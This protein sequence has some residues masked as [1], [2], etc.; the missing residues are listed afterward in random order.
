MTLK[1][2]SKIATQKSKPWLVNDNVCHR[3]RTPARSISGP[4]KAMTLQGS[5]ALHL[6]PALAQIW[7]LRWNGQGFAQS[8]GG[9]DFRG[10]ERHQS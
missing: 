4:N 1:R 9:S 7:H 6:W 8:V 2:G 5:N 10:K 3:T